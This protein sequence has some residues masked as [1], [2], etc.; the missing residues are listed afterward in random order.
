MKVKGGP[1]RNASVICYSW[2]AI[3]LNIMMVWKTAVLTVVWYHRISKVKILPT[4]AI[5]SLSQPSNLF[6]L[7]KRKKTEEYMC[8]VT[9]EKPQFPLGSQTRSE[10][11]VVVTVSKRNI[12]CPQPSCWRILALVS[13]I[14]AA[15]WYSN[16]T[17][18]FSSGRQ[19]R[20]SNNIAACVYMYTFYYSSY[21]I[22]ICFV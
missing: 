14:D 5:S 16:H 13:T 6:L 3:I 10:Q 17:D 1:K 7:Q 19:N 12:Y 4:L 9:T 20:C 11:E 22:S 21:L 18:N 8:V 2:N 15:I